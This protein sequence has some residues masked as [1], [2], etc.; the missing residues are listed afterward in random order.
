VPN[1]PLVDGLPD[2][3]HRL[4]KAALADHAQ[5]RAGLVGSRD[6]RVRIGQRGGQRLLDEGVHPLLQRLNRGGRM[7]RV[8][9]AD[10]HRLH[11]LPGDHFRHIGEGVQAVLLRE[12]LRSLQASTA[13]GDRFRFGNGMQSLGMQMRDFAVAYQSD[14]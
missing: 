13:H 14:S 9:G 3:A 1:A 12:G 11:A 2:A 10:D 4:V 5:P 8:R 7:G 6:H